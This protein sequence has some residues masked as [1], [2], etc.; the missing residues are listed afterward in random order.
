VG[1]CTVS[2]LAAVGLWRTGLAPK[3][4]ATKAEGAL[5]L[6]SDRWLPWRRAHPRLSSRSLSS[7][8]KSASHMQFAHGG[9]VLYAGV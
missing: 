4:I 8:L 5:V 7:L 6:E 2:G 9:I 3:R 1:G